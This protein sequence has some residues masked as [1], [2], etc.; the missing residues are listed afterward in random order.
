M[1]SAARIVPSLSALARPFSTATLTTTRRA[2]FA[3]TR[4]QPHLQRPCLPRRLPAPCPFIRHQHTIPRP[5][6]PPQPSSSTHEANPPSK[7]TQPH[8]ELTFTC[9]P[10]STRSR[11]RISKHGYNHGSVLVTCPGCKNR[12]VISDHLAIFGDKSTTVEEIIRTRGELV[13]KGTLSEDGDFEFWEDGAVVSREESLAEVP[14]RERATPDKEVEGMAP[15]STFK[16][17]RAGRGIG[18]G[19][20]GEGSAE[21]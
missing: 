17:V 12:H 13:R 18:E 20:K 19:N 6:S 16:S 21:P 4:P 2:Y 10:C 7:A 5:S 1:T 11:H 15:G 14:H 3:S 9:T 8:Y